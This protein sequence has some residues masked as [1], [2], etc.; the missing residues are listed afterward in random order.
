MLKQPTALD[1]GH[2]L[3]WA[4][5]LGSVSFGMPPCFVKPRVFSMHVHGIDL[6]GLS[7]MLPGTR[8]LLQ[9]QHATN[10]FHVFRC[11][12]QRLL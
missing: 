9:A 12:S 10:C 4:C 2:R 11:Q 1:H 6:D 5:Q 8:Q 3:L 7:T